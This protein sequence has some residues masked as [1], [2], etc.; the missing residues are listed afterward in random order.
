[1]TKIFHDGRYEKKFVTDGRRTDG[2]GCGDGGCGC[3]RGCGSGCGCGCGRSDGR[4]LRLRLRLRSDGR[5]NRT[6]F[7][8]KKTGGGERITEANRGENERNLHRR[9]LAVAT[10]SPKVSKVQNLTRSNMNHRNDR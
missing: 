10:E 3:G 2:G 8:P 9:K 6:K 4:R 7:A 1:M 5:R